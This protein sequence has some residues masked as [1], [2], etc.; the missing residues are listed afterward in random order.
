VISS[1][2]G[3]F[4]LQLRSRSAINHRQTAKNENRFLLL[5]NGARIRREL[6]ALIAGAAETISLM[7]YIFSND[8][9]GHSVL[10]ELVESAQRG[11]RVEIMIDAFGSSFTPDRFFAPLSQA[12]GTIRRFNTRWRPRYLFRN[13][14]KFIIADGRA[15]LTGG[16]NIADHY[17]GDGVQ[18]GWR[19]IGIRVDGPSV[20]ELQNSFQLFWESSANAGRKIRDMTG[21]M[22]RRR[23]PAGNVEWLLR[24]PGVRRGPHSDYLRKDLVRASQLSLVMGYFVPTVSL[25]RVLGRIAR[26]GR[27]ELVLPQTTDVPISRYA[28]WFTFRR[29]LRDGCEIYEYRPRPLHAKLMVLDDVVYAGSSNIDIRS[30]HLNF[31]MSVR[32]HDPGLAA[33]ARQ[34]VRR[35]IDLSTRITQEVYDRNSGIF[36]RV[37]RRFAYT[38]LSFDYFL[39]RKFVD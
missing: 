1:Q 33:Q 39:S 19:E 38:L 31:E 26:R 2:R 35:D 36:Q 6:S 8:E 12:G 32:I 7:I 21:A 14:Q 15:V 11:V 20:S 24:S 28:A 16:F 37:L 3:G 13:H 10:S 30:L 22:G 18:T 4:C 9:S 5:E 34:L 27:A 17:F 25:R 23:R 29:L